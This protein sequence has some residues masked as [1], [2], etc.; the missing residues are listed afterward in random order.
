MGVM[1]L[2]FVF[3]GQNWQLT[4]PSLQLQERGEGALPST[5]EDSRG[6]QLPLRLDLLAGLLRGGV[7][8][9]TVRWQPG[10]CAVLE[11]LSESG[12]VLRRLAYEQT[13][14]HWHLAKE[15]LLEDD[16]ALL[17]ASYSD[18]RQ[19]GEAVWW[20]HR[21]ELRDPLRGSAALF[22]TDAVRTDGVS[23]ELFAMVEMSAP[24]TAK[25]E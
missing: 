25:K 24:G 19:V 18:Y 16:T 2:D 7:R 3:S 22:E 20:P 9:A 10:A 11:E 13:G 15:E 8:G 17:V 4:V 5:F 12:Q 6:R 1:A 23:D 14:G 21:L